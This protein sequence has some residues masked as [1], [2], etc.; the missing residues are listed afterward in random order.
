MM[1][2]CYAAPEKIADF[3]FILGFLLPVRYL[4]LANTIMFCPQP[5]INT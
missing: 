5:S 1:D 3:E 4:Y 2:D